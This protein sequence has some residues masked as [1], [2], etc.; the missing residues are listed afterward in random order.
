MDVG[1]LTLYRS[2]WTL[3]ETYRETEIVALLRTSSL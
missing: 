3:G 2:A 1:I